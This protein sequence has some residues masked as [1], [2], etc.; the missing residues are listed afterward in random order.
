[1][2]AMCIMH[3]VLGFSR[4]VDPEVVPTTEEKP[5]GPS[6]TLAGTACWFAAAAIRSM[7]QVSSDDKSQS[8]I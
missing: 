8:C 3:R 1:M 2:C 7:L 5:P 6:L 4:S